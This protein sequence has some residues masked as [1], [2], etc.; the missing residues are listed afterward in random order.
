MK[1]ITCYGTNEDSSLV[2]EDDYLSGANPI[3]MV[4]DFTFGFR[5]HY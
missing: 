2:S 4:E 5:V 3:V 1:F